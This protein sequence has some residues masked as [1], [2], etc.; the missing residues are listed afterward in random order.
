M[1][2]VDHSD[3]DAAAVNPKEV[4]LRM[5]LDYSRGVKDHTTRALEAVCDLC[6][7][8]GQPHFTADS[9]VRDAA[10]LISK[11]FG[12]ESVAIGVWDSVDRLYRYKAVVGLEKESADGYSNLTYTREQLMNSSTYPSHEI[13]SHT[14]LFL[15]EE[16]PY[17]EGEEFTYRRHGL[18]GMK[19]RMVTDSLEADYLDIFFHEP[20]GDILGFIEISGTRLRKL[21]DAATIRWIELIGALLSVAVQKKA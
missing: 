20:D 10:E 1:E 5:R 9:F 21:P 2:K 17:A 6:W 13:S 12:I 4:A 8:L 3:G 14:R 19:R 11:L 15:T 7:K 18:I 16:H